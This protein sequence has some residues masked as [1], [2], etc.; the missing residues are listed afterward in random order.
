M[1]FIAHKIIKCLFQLKAKLTFSNTNSLEFLPQNTERYWDNRT[2][3]SWSLKGFRSLAPN[4]ELSRNSHSLGVWWENEG[5]GVGQ[6][7]FILSLNIS[8]CHHHW[9]TTLQR[10]WFR[11]LSWDFGQRHAAVLSSLPCVKLAIIQWGNC[12]GNGSKR[13]GGVLGE[14]LLGS[15]EC[16]WGT[17]SLYRPIAVTLCSLRNSLHYCCPCQDTDSQGS[18]FVSPFIFSNRQDYFDQYC[19]RRSVRLKYFTPKARYLWRNWICV[20]TT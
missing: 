19:L 13:N 4:F 6:H 14:E 15:F 8:T 9:T 10:A 18:S 1:G 17:G 11:I 3:Q 12:N 20:K 5:C 2:K 7:F 16:L